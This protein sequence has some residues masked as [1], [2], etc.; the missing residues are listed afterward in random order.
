MKGRQWAF[1]FLSATVAGLMAIGCSGGGGGDDKP[2]EPVSGTVTLDDQ[3]LTEGIILFAPVGN[4][5]EAV[6]S[7][8][9]K[10]EDGKFSIPREQGPVPGS[11]KVSITA[12]NLPEG[13]VKIDLKKSKKKAA[14]K[15]ETIPAKYNSQTTLKVDIPK[16]GKS[17]LS[18]SLQSK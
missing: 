17:D 3:P 13:R 10:I 18:F 14:T 8:T 5:A 7:A 1:S 16:G 11:Y 15:Q 2:R 9:G 12:A 4:A 6:A